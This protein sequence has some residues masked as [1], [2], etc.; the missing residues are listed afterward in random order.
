MHHIV[1]KL[2]PL[3]Y[4]VKPCCEIWWAVKEIHFLQAPDK[5]TVR[6]TLAPYTAVEHVVA[7]IADR[8]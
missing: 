5:D 1:V 2:H 8:C 4:A 7:T 6:D 3:H